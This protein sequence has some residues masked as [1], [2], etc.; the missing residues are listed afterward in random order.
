M[1]RFKANTEFQHWALLWAFLLV[2][3]FLSYIPL[4]PSSKA[5]LILTLV[6][7][8]F[9]GA[10]LDKGRAQVSPFQSSAIGF[11]APQWVWW[12][13]GVLALGLRFSFLYLYEGWPGG[14]E[15]IEGLFGIDLSHHWTWRL[16]YSTGQHPPLWIWMLSLLYRLSPDSSFNLWFLPAMVS[17]LFVLVSTFAA[18]KFFLWG[19]VFP[20]YLALCFGFWPLYFGRF[21]KEADLV[22]LFGALAFFCLGGLWR[23]EQK[24]PRWGWAASLG[25]CVGL[26]AYSFMGFVSV[27]LGS[28]LA[29][30][31]WA[32]LKRERRWA[33]A[34]FFVVLSVLL[35]PLAWEATREHVGGYALSVSAMGGFYHW[36]DE[37]LNAVS[38]LTTFFCG[39]I[40]D[41]AAYGPVWGG[42]LNPVEGAFFFLGLLEIKKWES[43]PKRLLGSAFLL[44]LLPGL[45]TADTVETLR[46]IPAMP[47][48]YLGVALGLGRLWREGPNRVC[49]TVI[50]CLMGSSI[51]LNLFHLAKARSW[52]GPETQKFSFQERANEGYWAYRRFKKVSQTQG[53]GLVF[54]DFLLLDRDHALHVMSYPFNALINP[55]LDATDAKWAGVLTNVHY[56]VF[57]KARFPDSEWADVT[58]SLAS[59]ELSA[60]GGSVVGI[61]AIT[62][63]NRGTFLRWTQ[64]HGYFDDLG[65]EA[66]NAM[67]DRE[68]YAKQV[69]KLPAG[70]ALM[71]GD[72]FL[73]SV[74]GEWVAQYHMGNTLEPNLLALKRALKN[75]YPTANLYFK[76]GNFL[77]ADQKIP[78]AEVALAQA[79]RCQ[80]N[81]TQAE[82]FLKALQSLGPSK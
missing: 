37:V 30:L 35:F 51:F 74:Y 59:K 55:R 60:G 10:R 43:L 61:I 82:T 12:A 75:G 9:L 33:A 45:L 2:L 38:Y 40:R 71:Q 81:H 7:L 4:S 63:E 29:V 14:D 46:V 72:P 69:E 34:I 47:L 23:A 3:S 41:G 49:R 79:L 67:N 77:A 39:P 19:A 25:L 50:F 52:D 31:A 66:E 68:L 1:N 48:L 22:P 13:V 8:L 32:G 21:C 6:I 64:A 78:E 53:P 36:K 20:F 16:F 58:P 62:A 57:L 15:S 65:L 70:Y 54:S 44:F 5:V 18:R 80:P 56:G 73:E 28:V 76:L 17:S 24:G 26:G 42:F 11:Q 27:V